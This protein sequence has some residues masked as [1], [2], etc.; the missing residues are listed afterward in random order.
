MLCIVYGMMPNFG[1][2]LMTSAICAAIQPQRSRATPDAPPL[3]FTMIPTGGWP[4][5][6]IVPSIPCPAPGQEPW[7]FSVY[8][9]A[10]QEVVAFQVG[11]SF[12]PTDRKDGDPPQTL[13]FAFPRNDQRYGTNPDGT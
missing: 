9:K 5:C 8:T 7:M 2:L 3:D 1:R 4:L 13:T 11:L 12:L 10:G 6:D